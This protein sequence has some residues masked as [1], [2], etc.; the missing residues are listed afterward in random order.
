MQKA[1]CYL[2]GGLSFYDLISLMNDD[3]PY[4]AKDYAHGKNF[5]FNF[6]TYSSM[7][8][9]G[10]TGQETYAYEVND[11]GLSTQSCMTLTNDDYLPEEVKTLDADYIYH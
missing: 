6:C 3:G 7:N 2:Y 5:Y 10:V 4:V 1:Q 9:C 11:E 8:A